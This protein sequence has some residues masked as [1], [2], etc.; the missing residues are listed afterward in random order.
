MILIGNKGDMDYAREVEEIEARTVSMTYGARFHELSTVESWEQVVETMNC[1][2]KE[3]KEHLRGSTQ[4]L[5]SQPKA[6]FGRQR[7][8]SVTKMIGSLMG[9]SSSPA[10]NNELIIVEKPE[11]PSF[12]ELETPIKMM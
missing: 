12:R 10:P 5:H 8:L 11:M 2:L 9:R 3:V 6:V 1:F 7:R 4:Q